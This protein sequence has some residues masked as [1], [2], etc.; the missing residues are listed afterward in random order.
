MMLAD[1]S[2]EDL[3]DLAKTGFKQVEERIENMLR[4]ALKLE[5]PLQH[6][7]LEEW[8]LT[9]QVA[10]TNWTACSL[11]KLSVTQVHTFTGSWELTVHKKLPCL[12]L[13]RQ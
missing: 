8:R 13:K 2:I 6:W 4:A 3:L 10:K 5:L 11:L 1:M 7:E 12:R 9:G